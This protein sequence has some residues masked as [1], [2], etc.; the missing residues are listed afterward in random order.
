MLIY[1]F[2]TIEHPSRQ[3]VLLTY[4][5]HTNS[6]LI[7]DTAVGHESVLVVVVSTNL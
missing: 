6:F 2:E 5:W 1:Q 3:T 4:A 7:D